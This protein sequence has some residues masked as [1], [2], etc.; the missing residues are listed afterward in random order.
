LRNYSVTFILLQKKVGVD[1]QGF[2]VSEWAISSVGGI[3]FV[4]LHRWMQPCARADALRRAEGLLKIDH[5][6]LKLACRGTQTRVLDDEISGRTYQVRCKA[7]LCAS[8]SPGSGTVGSE[9]AG[10]GKRFRWPMRRTQQ[11]DISGTF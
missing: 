6:T 11:W 2:Q 1:F 8:V 10:W 7:V 5:S 9:G 4:T 3:C